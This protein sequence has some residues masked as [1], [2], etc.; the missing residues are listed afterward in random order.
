MVY[1][2]ALVI[3]M[4]EP[5]IVTPSESLVAVS[6]SIEMVA[7]LVSSV[8]VVSVSVEVATSVAVLSSSV[9][10]SLLSDSLPSLSV[11]SV[12]SE[13]LVSLVAS[14]CVSCSVEVSFSSD[15]VTLVAVSALSESVLSLVASVVSASSA[16]AVLS[17][18]LVD[19]FEVVDSEVA[20]S[21]ESS[22]VELSVVATRSFAVAAVVSSAET[23][24]EKAK[25]AIAPTRMIPETKPCLD[26]RFTSCPFA[27]P[28]A[29]RFKR[30]R[31]F[32]NK[33]FLSL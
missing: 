20:C 6:L 12:L 9:V 32:I 26:F 5:E 18:S 3:V 29:E 17:V 30:C 16:I 28:I 1:V 33:N 15:S 10:F 19:S 27:C 13:A 8:V 23:V 31:L 22:L 14:A 4:T 7:T 25:S 2:P 24:P 11:A 21:L